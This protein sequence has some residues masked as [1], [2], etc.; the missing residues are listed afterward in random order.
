MV[1]RLVKRNVVTVKIPQALYDKMQTV[2]KS[3]KYRIT[4]VQAFDIINDNLR[5][6]KINVKPKRRRY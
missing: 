2:R 1:R 6:I 5:R 4:N 3:H